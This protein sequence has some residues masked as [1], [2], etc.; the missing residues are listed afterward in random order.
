MNTTPHSYIPAP[1]GKDMVQEE[2]YNIQNSG[3]LSR[4]TT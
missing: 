3:N 1:F 2:H 4:V